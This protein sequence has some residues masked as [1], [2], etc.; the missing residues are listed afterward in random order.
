MNTIREK[1]K[2]S[3]NKLVF[4][5]EEGKVYVYKG[6]LEFIYSDTL[7][8]NI[9]E[10]IGTSNLKS[11]AN[12]ANLYSLPKLENICLKVYTNVI[13]LLILLD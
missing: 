8:D 10:A 3:N 9:I 5:V 6:L 2:I 11:L 4:V 13:T 1:A 7:S 12:L